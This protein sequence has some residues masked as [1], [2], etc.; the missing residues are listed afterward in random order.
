VPVAEETGQIVR[1]D[2]WVL[3][4][5]CRA[6]AHWP[7]DIRVAVNI[8]AIHFRDHQ[9]VDTV[10]NALLEARLAPQRLEIELTESAVLQNVQMTRSVLNEL[11]QIGVRVSLDDF[12][13]GYSSLSYLNMLPFN[14][15]K[16]DRSFLQGLA[17]DNRPLR[18]I[19]GITT[20]SAD[21]G[22]QVVM[23]GV[24]T[25]NEYQLIKEYTAVDEIQGYFFSRPLPHSEI[26]IIFGQ[27]KLT[28]A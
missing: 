13:T 18:I 7:V 8:S 3:K 21:L 6:C 17:P 26:S 22:L 11:R 1:L 14:K 10:K 28:A 25:E 20:L 27:R 12:G 23:E 5:A 2:N 16:I 24:E 19:R 4:T 9:L 15:L